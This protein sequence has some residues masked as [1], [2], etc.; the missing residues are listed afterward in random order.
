[1]R[2][3]VKILNKFRAISLIN[4]NHKSGVCAWPGVRVGEFSVSQ[5]Y[6]KLCGEVSDLHTSIIAYT[7]DMNLH[8]FRDCPIMMVI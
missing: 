6:K 1:M 2:L 5:A 4:S 7:I 3:H 8:V